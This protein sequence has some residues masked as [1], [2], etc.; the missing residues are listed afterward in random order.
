MSCAS[1]EENT[2]IVRVFDEYRYSCKVLRRNCRGQ[3]IRQIDSIFEEPFWI[4]V[5]ERISEGKLSV[6]K[7]TFG[8]ELK[9]YESGKA[10]SREIAKV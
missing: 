10:G 3:S 7:M 5:F 4:G 8:A 1:N 6:C 9:D 2:L